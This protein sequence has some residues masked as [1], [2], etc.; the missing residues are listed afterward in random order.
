MSQAVIETMGALY[1]ITQSLP[2][3]TN[4]ALLQFLWMILS[5]QLL[6]SRGALFP[7]LQAIGLSKAAVRRA[8]AAFRYGAWKISVLLVLWQQYVKGQSHWQA[9]R[10]E[11]YVPKVVDITPYW[12]PATKA[13]RSK[14]C[15]TTF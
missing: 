12:H 2:I 7:G 9:H 14:H 8:W 15:F 5:G 10:Y 13:C 1:A 11:G 3:G 4:L 6:T